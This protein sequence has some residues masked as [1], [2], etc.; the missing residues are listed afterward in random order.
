MN[1]KKYFLGALVI[2]G[3]AV[4][5]IVF[6]DLRYPVKHF[7]R[8]LITEE[9]GWQRQESTGDAQTRRV[10]LFSPIFKINQLWPSMSGPASIHR[11]SLMPSSAPELLWLTGYSVQVVD[12]EK[13]KTLDEAYLCHN[14]LD[15][16]V[17][18][19]YTNWGISDRVGVLTP[20]LA[21][22]T[23]G[24]AKI[25]FP[26]GFGIPLMSNQRMATATQVLNLFEPDLDIEVRHKIAVDF[27]KKE[28]LE[29]PFK[30]LYQQSVCVLIKIDTNRVDS[31]GNKIQM[32]CRPALASIAFTNIREDGEAYTGHWVIPTGRDT[33][34]YDVTTI[35]SLRVNTNLHYA[36][37]HVH[38]YCEYLQLKNVTTGEIVF[39]SDITH[40]PKMMK[41]NNIEVYSSPEGTMLYA[42]HQYELTC[43]TNNR[44]SSEQ[45]MMAVMLLYLHDQEMEEVLSG[46]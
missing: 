17:A 22:I 41:M 6:T 34:A 1:L 7:F 39:Q 18:S 20:R 40:D 24:Q 37:V 5:L 2:F 31:S 42:D 38:P 25:N 27:I 33:V 10:E 35:L 23:Q 32:D 16:S 9:T 15:Y 45:D 19:Y 26:P 21:T 46:M 14:N 11:F 13:K 28:D 30:P 43:V 12:V 3:A 44:S 4:V 8:S 29:T 36:S